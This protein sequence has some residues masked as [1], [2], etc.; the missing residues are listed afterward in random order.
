[1]ST[2]ED[3]YN[4]NFVNGERH[5]RGEAKFRSTPSADF[6]N[7]YAISEDDKERF[8]KTDRVHMRAS[9]SK[10]IGAIYSVTSL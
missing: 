5:Q 1:M 3:Y 6:L 8:A 9:K 2:W 10:A 4:A 7:D